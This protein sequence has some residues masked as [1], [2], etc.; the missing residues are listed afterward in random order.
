MSEPQ[1][2]HRTTAHCWPT[3]AALA[4]TPSRRLALYYLRWAMQAR[5]TGHAPCLPSYSSSSPGFENQRNTSYYVLPVNTPALRTNNAIYATPARCAAPPA[6]RSACAGRHTGRG[7]SYR[8]HAPRTRPRR[9]RVCSAI[10]WLV[11]F[12]ANHLLPADGRFLIR[13]SAR[14]PPGLRFHTLTKRGA[15]AARRLWVGE[16]PSEPGRPASRLP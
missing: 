10:S 1:R 7:R 3:A 4:G 15:R 9:A 5:A 8:R 6:V 11:L 14:T 16:P 2:P 13:R 12:A